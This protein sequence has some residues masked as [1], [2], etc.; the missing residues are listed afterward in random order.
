MKGLGHF[1]MSENEQLLPAS[2]S[3]VCARLPSFVEFEQRFANTPDHAAPGARIVLPEQ[4]RRRV[5]GAVVTLEQPAPVGNIGQQYPDRL[6]QRTGKM[7]NAGIDRDYQLEVRDE[8]CRIGEIIERIA[9]MQNIVACPEHGSI[10][11]ANVF[12]HAHKRRSNIQEG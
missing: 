4:T 8:R 10:G 6:S 1:P 2:A 7:S 5:P 9:E 12:L 3:D 11:V